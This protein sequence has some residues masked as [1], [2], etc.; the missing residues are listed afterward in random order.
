MSEVVSRPLDVPF[1]TDPQEGAFE[2]GASLRLVPGDDPPVEASA[3]DVIASFC[4]IA[5]AIDQ[6]VDI[7]A[8]L[9]LI[10]RAAAELTRSTRSCVY[11]RDA[12][13]GLFRGRVA[14]SDEPGDDERVVRLVCGTDSDR[15][16]R[17]IV[18][19]RK[20]V[21]IADARNDPRPV[22]AAMVDWGVRS[23]LGVPMLAG[24][25]VIGIIFI[26][27]SG[28]QQSF[29]ATG[30]ANAA[31]FGCLV[32][33][34]TSQALHAERLRAQTLAASREN[35]QLKRARAVDERLTQAL[36][37]ARG[38]LA[39]AT[40]VA[41]VTGRECA[42]YDATLRRIGS[43]GRAAGVAGLRP[44]DAVI[45]D[46]PDVRKL[47]EADAERPTAIIEAAPSGG[48]MHR[49]LV[50]VFRCGS[51]VAGCVALSETGGRFTLTDLTVARRCAMAA[52]IDVAARRQS[53]VDSSHAREVLVRDLISGTSDPQH[54]AARA[55]SLGLDVESHALVALVK[56]RADCGP[57]VTPTTVSDACVAQDIEH[58]EGA[59]TAEVEGVAVVVLPIGQHPRRAAVTEAQAQLNAVA[60][61]LSDD[62][63]VLAAL[64][65]ACADPS[66]FRR[67]FEEARQ[68]LGCL[69][70]L[71]SAGSRASSLA[72]DDLGAA[73]LFLGVADRQEARRFCADV[74]GPLDD[75]D[76]PRAVDLLMTAQAFYECG[77]SVRR[78]AGSL[79]VHGN[80]IRYRL[81]RIEQITGRDIVSDATHQLDFFVAL[82]VL[83]L[84]R[85]VPRDIVARLG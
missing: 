55:S 59:V 66:D 69:E 63:E 50:S 82:M 78:T 15:F 23:V 25:E 56:R 6:A 37:D 21:F 45:A 9:R 79:A 30:Q 28:A 68:V 57:P 75:L 5:A 32:G 72:A 26:D 54:A 14:I 29:S 17:E 85:R 20:P 34:A 33:A 4:H 8:S 70:R 52:A 36:V 10:G 42:V 77:R 41:S 2:V 58:W 74:L 83:S 65:T 1:G 39:I 18:A 19:R 62:G 3:S 35:E 64:S 24:E 13:S 46:H 40:T 81:A 48:L 16:T 12:G 31:A 27:Q 11:L 44:F 60:M 38:L 84:E 53:S 51:Q 76:D 43:G 49:V 47:F 80:T 7:D 67:A 73:R 61:R 71:G 22:R